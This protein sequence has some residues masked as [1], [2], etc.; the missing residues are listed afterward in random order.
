[1]K[2]GLLIVFTILCISILSGQ[3]KSIEIKTELGSIK[4]ELYSQ[5]APVTCSNFLR[6]IENQ[7][8]EGA[9]FYRVVRMDKDLL[10][11]AR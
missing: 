5:K 4:I 9:S 3:N 2:T 6:Y 11:L 8:F 1:M 7:K 10:L